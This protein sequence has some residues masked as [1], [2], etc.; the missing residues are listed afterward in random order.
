VLVEVTL[1]EGVFSRYSISTALSGSAP[2]SLSAVRSSS[3]Y[4]EFGRTVEVELL[5]D[6]KARW[7][8]SSSYLRRYAS[9]SGSV[10]KG[11]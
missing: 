5:A 3:M 2:V 6:P 10:R 8:R 1:L 11:Q 7:P 4:L 9:C